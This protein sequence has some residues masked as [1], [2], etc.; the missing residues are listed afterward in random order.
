VGPRAGL[1]AEVREWLNHIIFICET[2]K[3][4]LVIMVVEVAAVGGVTRAA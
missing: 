3:Q 1:D 2:Y 4:K